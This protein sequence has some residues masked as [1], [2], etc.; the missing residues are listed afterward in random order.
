MILLDATL[1]TINEGIGYI[2][3]IL[4]ALLV[5]LSVWLIYSIVRGVFND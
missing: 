5:L 1:D 4:L 3:V 2:T